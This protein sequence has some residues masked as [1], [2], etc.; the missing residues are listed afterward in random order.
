M[1]VFECT[2][3]FRLM[4]M[5]F[6]LNGDDE[7]MNQATRGH[8]QGEGNPGEENLERVHKERASEVLRKY[9]EGAQVIKKEREQAERKFD[10]DMERL[11]QWHKAS[12]SYI[13]Q[14]NREER[15]ER[16]RAEMNPTELEK[17]LPFNHLDKNPPTCHLL[18]APCALHKQV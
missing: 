2:E 7:I 1:T 5:A 18:Q 10:A 4:I 8:R 17:T 9:H 14:R 11:N 16:R 13:V 6:A 15:E 3:S 12:V